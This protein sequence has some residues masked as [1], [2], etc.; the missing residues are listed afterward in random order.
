V[1]TATQN[2]N[3]RLGPGTAYRNV[4]TLLEAQAAELAGR[5]AESSW[6][7]I[8]TPGG[9][10]HC[11]VWGGSLSIVGDTARLPLIAAPPTD[12]PTPSDSQ[13]PVVS[14]SY[15]PAGPGRPTE[16]DKISLTASA[17]DSGGVE[18]IEIWF[19][20]PRQSQASLV[21]TCT[22]SSSC[23]FAGGPYPAGSGEVYARAWDA[24][25]NLGESSKVVLTILVYLQ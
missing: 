17:S 24:A 21:R 25:G 16:R 3:C 5:N 22:G 8:G 2:A 1:G 11:W 7:W 9:S 20:P 23:L 4:A 15:A 13:G 12:T 14:L 6:W 19:R 18:R 10:G